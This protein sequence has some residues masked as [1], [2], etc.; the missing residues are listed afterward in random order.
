MS[1]GDKFWDKEFE[2]FTSIFFRPWRADGVNT[3]I[4]ASLPGNHDLGFG[5][6]IQLPVRNRFQAYF[7]EGNRVDIIG[8]HTFVSIDAPSLSAKDEG[9]PEQTVAIWKPT[10]DFLDTAQSSI[11]DAIARRLGLDST[12][13]PNAGYEHIVADLNTKDPIKPPDNRSLIA[14]DTFPIILLSHVPLHRPPGAPCGPLRER[15]PPTPPPPGDTNPVNPDDPNSIRD[16]RG[17]QYKNLLTRSVSSQIAEKLG[18]AIE[19]AFSG[20]DH[21][22]CELTHSDYPS[23]VMGIKEITVKSISWAM[24]R[25][26][27]GVLL[28]S[29]SNPIS[30]A[31]KPIVGPV[32]NAVTLELDD[33]SRPDHSTLQSHLCLLPDQLAI[34]IQYA[35]FAGISLAVLAVRAVVVTLYSKAIDTTGENGD[36][37]LPSFVRQS[38]NAS[39][40]LGARYN[41]SFPMRGARRRASSLD[42]W[43]PPS[44][45]RIN[46]EQDIEANPSTSFSSHGGI[47]FSLMES[48]KSTDDLAMYSKNDKAHWW[49]GSK[50]GRIG[51][52]LLRK[53]KEDASFSRLTGEWIW[54][55]WK[56][57][58]VVMAWFAY[59]QFR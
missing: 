37:L 44:R 2:R 36:S 56:T 47:K 5:K 51:P 55:V 13:I 48:S 25:R 26:K 29:M 11:S 3:S 12:P 14:F 1:Y 59:L 39:T 27:P 57:A 38:L 46:A 21:D 32:L 23:S 22:Y 43:T 49:D 45:S 17:D 15:D 54:S 9:D 18:G 33:D 35:I 52:P 34:F 6:D 20:D 8:N 31:G 28:V 53:L 16:W 10:E 40:E 4:I 50:A 19:F 7:G 30:S 24:G 42:N 41:T 58:R